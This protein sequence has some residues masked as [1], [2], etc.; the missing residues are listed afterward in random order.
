MLSCIKNN[1]T[2]DKYFSLEQQLKLPVDEQN[3]RFLLLQ[4][5][6]IDC[7]RANAVFF[8]LQKCANIN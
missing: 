1:V 2:T 3:Y 7:L 8:F 5:V 6:I 4:I